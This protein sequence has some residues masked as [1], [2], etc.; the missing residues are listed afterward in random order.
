MHL[1][2]NAY[3]K[4]LAFQYKRQKEQV[5]HFQAWKGYIKYVLP[6]ERKNAKAISHFIGTFK[7]KVFNGWL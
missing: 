2:H 6:R 7:F 1:I 5:R 4:R 3:L